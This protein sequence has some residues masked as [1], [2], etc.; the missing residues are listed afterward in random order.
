MRD[1]HC[2]VQDKQDNF[3]VVDKVAKQFDEQI[4]VSTDNKFFA[5][6]PVFAGFHVCQTPGCQHR[7]L[8]DPREPQQTSSDLCCDMC[9]F[10][11]GHAHTPTAT[12][13]LL[14]L[15]LVLLPRPTVVA[16]VLVLS[17][18]TMTTVGD[19]G[20]TTTTLAL[21]AVLTVLPQTTSTTQSVTRSSRSPD[22]P[23]LTT[24]RLLS[25]RK[26]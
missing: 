4:I 5:L 14:G 23:A 17:H 13:L 18:Q 25:Q 12:L 8:S 7:P 1:L 16:I 19:L 9:L 15:L 2:G 6:L 21:V 20:G 24:A 11:D 10:S 3:A 26:S 22:T